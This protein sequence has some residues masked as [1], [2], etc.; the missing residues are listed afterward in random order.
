[1]TLVSVDRRVL[2]VTL[3]SEANLSVD[4]AETVAGIV[5]RSQSAGLVPEPGSDPSQAALRADIASTFVAAR[6][7]IIRTFV[8]LIALQTVI[9]NMVLYGV[10]SILKP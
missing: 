7:D 8:G 10:V 4:Q 9:V 6:T 5:F 3:Q 2:I 1:M